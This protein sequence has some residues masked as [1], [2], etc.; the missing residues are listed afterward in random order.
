V[1]RHVQA[2]LAAVIL[3]AAPMQT[4][5][6][7][8]ADLNACSLERTRTGKLV[9]WVDASPTRPFVAR[10]TIVLVNGR[11]CTRY[12]YPK[13]FR[14]P[15]GTYTR[16][17]CSGEVAKELPAVVTTLNVRTLARSTSSLTCDRP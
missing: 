13:A 14:L 2:A 11:A 8:P 16:I 17:G 5:A 3:V 10:E 4:R 9:L 15:D 1:N 6:Q 7:A 12:S